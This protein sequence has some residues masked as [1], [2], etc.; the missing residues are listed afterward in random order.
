VRGGQPFTTYDLTVTNSGTGTGSVISS[1]GFK[2]NCGTTCFARLNTGTSVT[3]T[4]AADSDSVFMGWSGGGCVG[5]GTCTVTMSDAKNITAT[6]NLIPQMLTVINSRGNGTITSNPAGISCSS[7]T[8]ISSYVGTVTLTATPNSGYQF[9]GWSGACS[10]ANVICNVPMTAAQDVTANFT[11]L[12]TGTGSDWQVI[13]SSGNDLKAVIYG[14]GLFVAVGDSGNIRTSPDGLTWTV[15]TSSTTN[16]L[17]G[18][19]WSG[20][21]FVAVGN[22]GTILTSSNGTSWTPQ[23]SNTTSTLLNV[24]WSGSRFVVVGD[25]ILTSSDGVTWTTRTSGTANTLYGVTWSGTQFVAVGGAGTILTST[26][27]VTWSS[28]TSGTTNYLWGVTWNG[29]LFVATGYSGT[30]LTSSNGTSWTPQTSRTTNYLWGITWNGSLFVV[31]GDNSTIRT[32]PDGVNW[33]PRSSGITNYLH[34]VT[35]NGSRF[36]A[37]GANGTILI[38]PPNSFTLTVNK[39]GT[40]TSTITSDV[41]GINC[42]TTCNA[43]INNGTLVTLTAAPTSGI[44]FAGWSGNCSGMNN[45]C[46]ITMDA[47]KAV[48]ATFNSVTSISVN[49]T[50]ITSCSN[51]NTN[52]LP[53]PVT[54]FPRQ[55]AEYGSNGFNFTKI[56]NSGAALPFSASLGSGANDWACMRDNTTG[57]I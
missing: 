3:L 22:S 48:T 46:T 9:A 14:N 20:S 26:D 44:A 56:S 47:A 27:G 42:G 31:V 24:T 40:G 45:T 11:P 7:G 25:A 32:S 21:K 34:S 18:V 37:V 19:T 35:W 54:G 36:V 13:S 16:N 43:N 29:S 12:A 5:T 52:G 55:D 57:L 1:D 8:C 30:I 28:Q 39:N 51:V 49:D 4:A 10:D 17:W 23:T 33:T 2:I 53:C 38:S 6:F 41:G 15:Q 50:G